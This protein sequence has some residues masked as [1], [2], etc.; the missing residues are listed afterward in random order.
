V[1]E[2]TGGAGERVNRKVTGDDD[3]DGIKN[4]AIDVAGGVQKNFAELVVLAVA[5]AEFAI[6]VLDHD[7]G[8]V[9]DDSEIDGADGKKIGGFAGE[10]EKDEG[11][12][13]GQ[14]D[15]ESGDDGGTD[16]DQKE[17]KNQQNKNHAAQ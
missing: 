8:A 9:N 17:N 12:E 1:E 14:R 3:G 5:L 7:D 4:G 2:F 16:A 15:G 6:H 13:Q 10:M 11:E